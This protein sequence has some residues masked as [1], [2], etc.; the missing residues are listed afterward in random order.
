MDRQNP[1]GVRFPATMMLTGVFVSGK[2]DSPDKV[3]RIRE[4]W[5]HQRPELDSSPLQIL[6][7]LRRV[8]D[9]LR[10][11]L[12]AGRSGPPVLRPKY[13]PRPCAASPARR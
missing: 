11:E 5:Q 12:R 4:Q 8:A 10:E 13:L 2:V 9:R 7:R 1:P 6:G 3:G